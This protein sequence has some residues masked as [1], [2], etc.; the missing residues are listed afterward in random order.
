MNTIE[1]FSEFSLNE[2]ISK[3]KIETLAKILQ[4]HTKETGQEKGWEDFSLYEEIIVNQA[5]KNM[6]GYNLCFAI[7][8]NEGIWCN[9]ELCQKFQKVL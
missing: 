2:N 1:K 6:D 5:R 8:K 3:S 9:F 7:E 4:S